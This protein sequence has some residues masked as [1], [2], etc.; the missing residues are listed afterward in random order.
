MNPRR[1]LS[2]HF[3]PFGEGSTTLRDGRNL[4]FARYGRDGGLP[5]FWFHGTPGGRYQLPPD[6]GVEA[7]ARNLEIIAA[8]RPGVGGSTHDGDRTLLSWARDVEQLADDLGHDRFGVIGLSGGG[9]H[10]LACAHELGDRVLAA[11]TLGGVGPTF[12]DE[13]APAFRWAIQQ[14]IR[15]A[16]PL[17]NPISNILTR[18]VPHLH[19]VVSPGV[20]LYAR[21][22]PKSDRLVFKSPKMKAMFS[23]DI[24]AATQ[25][26][27]HGAILDVALFAAPWEFYAHDITVP[28][29]L[30]HGDDDRVVPLSH[31]EYLAERIPDAE[32]AVISGTGHF[33]GFTQ[34]GAVFD[35]MLPLWQQAEPTD[36]DSDGRAA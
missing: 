21:F 10:A 36:R 12:S 3:E 17:R 34:I 35:T 6:T 29:R 2:T 4:S 18:A 14:A 22:G 32:L 15:I 26:G 11:A 31:S 20:D 28:V 16:V 24:V 9:P 1:P 30:W 7:A 19:K 13:D 33:A 27:L 25:R 23:R 8:D 5:V